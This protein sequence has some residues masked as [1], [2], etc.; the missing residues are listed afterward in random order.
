MNMGMEDRL[1]SI[2]TGVYSHVE[3][4]HL[5]ICLSYLRFHATQQCI[6][7]IQLRLMQIE[8][9]RDMALRNDERMIGC[10]GKPVAHRDAQLVFRNDPRFINIT[11]EAARLSVV[12]RRR[13]AAKIGVVTVAL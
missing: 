4:G 13:H 1:T 3:T 8:E 12:I 5:L 10:D 2:A 7:R 9:I 11:K 6:K